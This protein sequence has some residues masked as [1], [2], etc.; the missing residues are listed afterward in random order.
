MNPI[1]VNIKPGRGNNKGKA[2]VAIKGDLVLDN[3][4]TLKEKLID[5][6]SKY[7]HIDI[8]IEETEEV[9]LSFL[10]LLVAFHKSV[11]KKKITSTYTVEFPPSVKELLEH[12]GFRNIQTVLGKMN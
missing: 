4:E 5:V 8:H 11:A 10:Q 2:K 6:I 1:D 3:L 12:T 7:K 9:D